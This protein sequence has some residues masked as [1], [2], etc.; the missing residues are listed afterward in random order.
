MCLRP[1]NPTKKLTFCVTCYL[2]IL[3]KTF[4]TL[5]PPLQL[6]TITTPPSSPGI[7]QTLG[8]LHT[9]LQ[10]GTIFH[11]KI[12]NEPSD[13]CDLRCGLVLSFE[14][15]G[16]PCQ[17]LR[18]SIK[19]V[20]YLQGSSWLQ[21]LKRRVAH[22]WFTTRITVISNSQDEGWLQILRGRVDFF[23]IKFLPLGY[24]VRVRAGS[25]SRKVRSTDTHLNIL[26]QVHT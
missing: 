7:R 13:I 8:L 15:G 11:Y 5:D 20:T 17:H 26:F 14:R 19:V 25:K 21:I 1:Q 3:F 16:W 10:V 18:H 24:M 4:L 2:E 22:I 12:G 23:C 9:L 6:L